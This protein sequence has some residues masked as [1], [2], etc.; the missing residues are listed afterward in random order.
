M[1]AQRGASHEEITLAVGESKTLSTAGVKEY[2]EGVKGIADISMASDSRTFIITGRKPGTTTFLLIKNDGSQTSYDISVANKNPAIVENELRDFVKPF[3]TVRTRR[4]G[5]RIFLEG[6]VATDADLKSIQQLLPTYA[7]QVESLVTVGVSERKL[8]IR[9]DFFFVQYE[10]TSGYQAGIGWPSSIGGVY[11]NMQVVQSNFSYDFVSRV[12]TAANASIVNQP[13]PS[14]DIASHH[15]WAKVLKQSSVI[16][17]NGSE[18]T[19]QNGGE[20]N[21]I[22]SIGLNMGLVSVKFGTNVTVLPRYDSATRDVEIKLGA[23]VADLTPPAVA[24]GPPSRTTTKLETQ[25]TLK[26]GQALIVSGIKTASQRHNVSGLPGLSEIPILGIL[27]G[28]HYQEKDETEGAVFIVP[29]VV[30]TV[31]KSAIELI[32]NA[33][34]T[35]KDYGGAFS[36]ADISSVDAYPKT[37]PSAK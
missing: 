12:T 34:S 31:P 4:A 36:S 17:A 10:K 33:M 3:G 29:S 5:A 8:L 22:Q 18:A 21:F 13:L 35:Y 26:L 25:V 20:S 7:G 6:T 23:D 30:D 9:L 37:P 15:G 24:N 19:F 28:S 14:L 1:F 11:N 32:N 16:T 2:S 27:F